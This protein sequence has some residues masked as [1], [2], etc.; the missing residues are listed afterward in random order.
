[1]VNDDELRERK[2]LQLFKTFQK[3]GPSLDG[4]E[5]ISKARRR[6][7]A[8]MKKESRVTTEYSKMGGVWSGMG[9]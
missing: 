3:R 1:M 9:V 4:R 8:G 7:G 2:L 5:N 6:L